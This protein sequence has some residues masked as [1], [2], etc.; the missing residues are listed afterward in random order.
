M[1]QDELMSLVAKTAAL[2]EQFERRCDAIE[3]RQQA[4]IQQL[5]QIAQQVP[6]V[7]RQ[8]ADESLRRL[9]DAVMSKLQSGLEQPVDGYEK[10]L[11]EAG[12]LL[13]EGSQSLAA[14]LMKMQRL[15]ERLI[16]KIAGTVLGSLLLLLGG[17]GWLLS[18][19][20]SDIRENQISAELLRAYNQADVTLCE[21]RLCANVD[22]KGKAYGDKRQYRPVQ[23]RR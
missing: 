7:V 19:Y 10:R 22:A 5:Q 14:Q 17:G 23:P 4:V 2:M 3:Q 15:H 16:W 9:P 8:S 18:K 1:Q 20:R 11:R 12:S 21:G 13:Q 6:G